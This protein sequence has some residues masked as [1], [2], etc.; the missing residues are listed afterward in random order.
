MKKMVNLDA[1]EATKKL[2]DSYTNVGYKFSSFVLQNPTE[3]EDAVQKI[4]MKAFRS[5]DTFQG[6]ADAKTWLLSIARNHLYDRLREQQRERRLLRKALLEA[7]TNDRR[8]YII[9]T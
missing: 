1:A 6:R 3:A 2:L 5:W 8:E 7:Q 4:F 9:L